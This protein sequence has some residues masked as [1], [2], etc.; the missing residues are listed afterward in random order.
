M[1]CREHHAILLS[2]F[3]AQTEALMQ[4][5]TGGGRG[6]P[7]WRR[8]A[9]GVP[10]GGAGAAQGVPRQPA[11]QHPAL[12]AP[13]PATLGV[14]IALYEHKIFV[15]GM[16]WEINSFD[17]WGVELGKQ[18]A[19][20]KVRTPPGRVPGNA[21]AARADGKC[22]RNIPPSRFGPVRV[23]WCGKSAPRSWQQVRQGKPHP[24]QG[25]IGE[26]WRGPRC[27]RVGRSRCPV[28][29]IPDE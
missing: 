5:K 17:Q 6:A 9:C 22:N 20:R 26:H 13:D 12:P 21:W 4:G 28:T 23:K 16:I 25:Q 24:E 29:G 10:D 18:L 8:R 3:L 15:Q 11:Q 14:L 19:R 2:N 7:S 27:S 1:T